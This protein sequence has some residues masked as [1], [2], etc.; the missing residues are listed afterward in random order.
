MSWTRSECSPT[1]ASSS[2]ASSPT[3]R[4][5]NWNTSQGGGHRAHEGARQGSRDAGD[6][7]QR[8]RAGGDRH[9]AAPAD[10]ALDGR[11][12]R[13]EDS[14]GTRGEAGGSRRARRV[15]VLRRVLV[16]DGRG[17]RPLGRPR[18][19]L[20]VGAPRWPPHP[21]R[22]ER[23]G[24]PVALL[25]PALI[26][27]GG[28]DMAPTPPDARDAPRNPGRSSMSPYR[29]VNS[30]QVSRSGRAGSTSVAAR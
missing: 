24:E 13:R 3:R 21:P 19:L 18:D 20:K 28:P 5:R 27:G 16:L 12:A 30:R 14:D 25:D 15:A 9:R 4:A 17:L 7:R 22:S 2:T 8:G 23:P 6:S 1:G 29:S 10:G 26:E 11:H